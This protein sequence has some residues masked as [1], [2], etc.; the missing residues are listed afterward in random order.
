MSFPEVTPSKDIKT[1]LDAA[2]SGYKTKMLSAMIRRCNDAIG[3]M[4]TLARSAT[5]TKPMRKITVTAT[6]QDHVV[7]TEILQLTAGLFR[8]AGYTAVVTECAED[9]DRSV[10][11]SCNP[12]ITISI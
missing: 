4:C 7:A 12:Y 6:Y 11:Q 8:D 5:D 1:I 10:Y 9:D 3:E 2:E